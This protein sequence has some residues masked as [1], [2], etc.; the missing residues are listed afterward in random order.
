MATS[1][2]FSFDSLFSTIFSK[3][4][5]SRAAGVRAQGQVAS[6]LNDITALEDL[7]RIRHLFDA[8]DTRRDLMR[9][10]EIGH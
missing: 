5:R 7:E 2:F 10:L 4:E 6:L 3:E 8:L 1:V 9:L